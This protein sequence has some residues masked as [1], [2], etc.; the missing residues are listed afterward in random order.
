MLFNS[1][2]LYQA[3]FLA[4]LLSFEVLPVSVNTSCAAV[5]HSAPR[6]PTGTYVRTFLRLVLST[7]VAGMLLTARRHLHFPRVLVGAP[8]G[9]P[10]QKARREATRRAT[11]RVRGRQPQARDGC[12]AVGLRGPLRL[13]AF[14][15]DHLEPALLPRAAG[16]CIPRRHSPGSVL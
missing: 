10:Q 13:P 9:A 12:H 6:S 2:W 11:R 5:S 16:P 14:P 1:F 4:R 15:G 3:Y 7:A 8:L